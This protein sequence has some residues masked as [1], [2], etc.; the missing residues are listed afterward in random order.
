MTNNPNF[1]IIIP[2]YNGA[3]FLD[4]CL[5]SL[6]QSIKQCSGNF[7][8]IIVDNASKDN[9]LDLIKNFFDQYKSS[10]MTI[11]IYHLNSNT[12]FAKAVNFGV[13]K[14]KYNYVVLCNNDLTLEKDWFQLV[15]E[16]I[17]KNKNPKIATF[18]GT[19]LTKDGTKFESQGL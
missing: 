14:S 19:V 12:G 15:S 3:Q 2:N 6:Y 16:A 17:K 8:V 9:S 13:N 10:K 1:S 5:Y 11:K 7:E 18:F 4:N